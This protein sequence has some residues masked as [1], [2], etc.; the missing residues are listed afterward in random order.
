MI[1]IQVLEIKGYNKLIGGG[2]IFWREKMIL[3]GK[4][5]SRKKYFAG[6]RMWRENVWREKDLGGGLERDRILTGKLYWRAFFDS[7]S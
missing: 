2:E 3:P 5:F 1:S 7:S 4:G 6:K